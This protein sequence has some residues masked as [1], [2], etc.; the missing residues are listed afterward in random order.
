MIAEKIAFFLS[1]LDDFLVPEEKEFDVQDFFYIRNPTPEGRWIEKFW[2]EKS[3]IFSSADRTFVKKLII[4]WG[5]IRGVGMA[6]LHWI[7]NI[8]AMVSRKLKWWRT[9]LFRI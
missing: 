9:F 7:I 4:Q 2:K 5:P 8:P 1:Y 3:V 6:N